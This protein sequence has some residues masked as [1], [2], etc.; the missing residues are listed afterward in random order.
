MKNKSRFTLIELL[1]VIA[2]IAILIAMLLPMLAH[3]KEQARRV[4]C[5]SNLKQ[6]GTAAFTF[7]SGNDR[8]LPRGVPKLGAGMGTWQLK[9]ISSSTFLQLGILKNSGDLSDARVLYC[10]SS[11]HPSAQFDT[12]SSDGQA[13]GWPASDSGFPDW[14]WCSY[15][16]RSSIWPGS[17]PRRAPSLSKDPG[18]MIYAADHFSQTSPAAQPYFGGWANGA[19]WFS[20]R[21]VYSV[22]RL[23]GSVYGAWD[24]SYSL[25]FNAPD[26]NDHGALENHW[27]GTTGPLADD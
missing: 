16:Y 7:A 14:T 3:T 22:L 19:G 23:D 13:G 4:V 12:E 10:P 21:E 20:H 27:D 25:I 24:Q 8:E 6:I 11:T 15:A 2:I 5:M 26:H 9:K 1:I 17:A 18:S